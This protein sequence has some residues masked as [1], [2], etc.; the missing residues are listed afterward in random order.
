MNHLK[1]LTWQGFTLIELLIVVAILAI[2]AAVLVPHF[3]VA[4]QDAKLSALDTTLAHARKAIDLFFQQH[5]YY[6]SAVKSSGGAC[7]S[8]PGGTGGTGGV[9]SETAL[10]DHLSLFTNIDG[11]ACTKSDA[12]FR[13][14]PYLNRAVLTQNPYTNGSRLRARL[15]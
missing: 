8:G 6:P 1:A 7:A 4:T 15:P 14:G 3:S 13:Y 5:G 9:D 10:L 2:L 11:V 12:E